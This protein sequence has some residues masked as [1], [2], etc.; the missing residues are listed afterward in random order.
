MCEISRRDLLTTGAA[1]LGIAGIE[2]ESVAAPRADINKVDPLSTDVYFHEGELAG[3]GHCNKGWI[4]F[5]DY[6]LVIDANFTSRANEIIP[7]IPGLTDKPIQLTFDT[8]NP[9]AA[10]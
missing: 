2:N 10:R 5:Q 1:I 3:N 7:K 4:I 8:T 9:G 6:V